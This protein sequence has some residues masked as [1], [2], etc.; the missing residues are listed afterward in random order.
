[1]SLANQV[2][3][4]TG[5]ARG[6]G[7]EIARAF[8]ARGARLA[9]ADIDG[10]GARA[11]ADEIIAAGGR[12]LSIAMDVA[13]EAQVEAGVAR[14]AAEFGG[15]DVLV[16]NA[17][18]Q[19][20]DAL[21]ELDFGHWK[22]LLAVHLDGAFLTTRACMRQMIAAGR[23][24]TILYIGSVHSFEASPRKAPYITAKHGLAGLAKVVAKE[25]APHGIRSNLICPGFVRTE[26]V[27]RQIPELAAAMDIS[28]ADVI[29]NVMLHQ[30][31]DGEFTAAGDV[32]ETAVFLA[33]FSSAAMTGQAIVVSHGWHMH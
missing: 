30:T 17:G 14:V 9:I 13:D 21:V 7:R 12:A 2:V 25:G 6:I 19:H 28:E 5:G 26:L 24:G 20:I 29:K 32:A 33:S 4:I 23:G 11:A 15:V 31:V 8:S 3:L 18:V 22:R 27:E 16:S 10:D 1:M